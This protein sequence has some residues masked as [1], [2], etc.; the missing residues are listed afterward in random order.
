MMIDIEKIP[1]RLSADVLVVGGG[2][3]GFC[4]AVAAAREG[5]RVILVEQ[6]GCCGGM[7]TNGL[8]MD[9][10]EHILENITI[11]YTEHDRTESDGTRTYIILLRAKRRMD[12]A[13]VLDAVRSISGVIHV[14]AL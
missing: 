9:A 10:I 7:A 3:A 14:A 1:S 11:T 12:H 8:V 13:I 5:V 6:S 2:P 4:A